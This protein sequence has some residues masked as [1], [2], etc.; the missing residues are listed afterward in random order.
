MGSKNALAP[1]KVLLVED[2]KRLARLLEHAI[3]DYFK[4]FDVAF[5]GIEGLDR[6]RTVRPDIVITDIT[7]PGMSGLSLAE[8]IKHESPQTPVVIL[9]AYSDKEK[10]LGAIDAGV[11]KY[12]IKP[13]DPEDLL[14]Y[15]CELAT[16]IKKERMV[17]LMPPFTFHRQTEQ[18]FKHGVLVHLSPRESR[19]IA[20][21]LQS[22]NHYMSNAAIKAHL[23]D[24]Q[25]ISN[26]RL[27]TFIKRLRQKSDKRLI[28]NVA[29]QGY[30]LRT[31]SPEDG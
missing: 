31:S 7:M 14:D 15:L 4:R 18:L 23:W 21:L 6:F 26:E 13:F 30:L 22:P 20:L 24:E 5:D 2:E 3:G 28:E 8:R 11:V 1:L 10:L 19:F 27:R 17:E 29:G 25:D 9:S 16:R 12:F